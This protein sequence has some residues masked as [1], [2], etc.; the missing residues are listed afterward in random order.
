[1]KLASVFFTVLDYKDEFAGKSVYVER[2]NYFTYLLK[3]P[4]EHILQLVKHYGILN[5]PQVENYYRVLNIF[6]DACKDPA[7]RQLWDRYYR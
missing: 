1:M 5:R 2:T 4:R 7:G 6:I 3:K